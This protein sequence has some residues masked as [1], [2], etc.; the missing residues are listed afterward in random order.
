MIIIS[1]PRWRSLVVT[2]AVIPLTPLLILQRDRSRRIAKTITAIHVGAVSARNRVA[3][4]AAVTLILP[5][6]LVL[7]RQISVR[8]AEAIVSAQIPAM[9]AWR[10]A[11]R[12]VVLHDLRL[13]RRSR[14]R[15]N[16]QL[17]GQCGGGNADDHGSSPIKPDAAA[18]FTR[19]CC[20]CP[21][22]TRHAL[23]MR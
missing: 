9:A 17:G 2:I 3:T 4:A 15:R 20:I 10:P 16:A 18:V 12:Y 6:G 19:R 8:I 13:D 23:N 21:I 5:C 7:W 11:D 22:I 14:S 1:A